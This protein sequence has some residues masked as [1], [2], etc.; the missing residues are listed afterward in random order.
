[1]KC[2]NSII[3]EDFIIRSS[4]LM[5]REIG[6]PGTKISTIPYKRQISHIDAWNL[7]YKRKITCHSIISLSVRMA[8]GIS[9]RPHKYQDQG[10]KTSM[11]RQGQGHMT[12]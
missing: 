4:Q 6:K 8:D 2:K 1:M 7:A 12:P 9:V 3:S 10:H 11:I 5:K